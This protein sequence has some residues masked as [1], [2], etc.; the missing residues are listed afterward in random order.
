MSIGSRR[1][2]AIAFGLLAV[3]TIVAF[4]LVQHLKVS[5]PLV[6]HEVPVPNAID[7]VHGRTCVTPAGEVLNH[8]HSRITIKVSHA[9]TVGVY[10]VSAKDPNGAPVATINSG[11]PMKRNVGRIVS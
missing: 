7:P 4:F 10:I 3:A 8:R 2:S 6:W 9:D 5:N 1:L 11:M